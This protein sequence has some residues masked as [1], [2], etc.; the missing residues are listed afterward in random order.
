[1]IREEVDKFATIADVTPGNL[2]RL[3]RRLEARTRPTGDAASEV[4]SYSIAHST[5][6]RTRSVPSMAGAGIVG[7]Q[8]GAGPK[9]SEGRAPPSLAKNVG[10]VATSTAR[11]VIARSGQ[12]SSCQ[13]MRGQV[14]RGR[15]TQ[16]G[17]AQGRYPI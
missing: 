12:V 4:S 5:M 13:A 3:E 11:R 9:V 16:G 10:V 8:P 7:N 15:P 17:S 6:S 1:M 14:R 2:A